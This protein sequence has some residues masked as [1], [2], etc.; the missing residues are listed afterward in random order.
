MNNILNRIAATIMPIVGMLIFLALLVL[1]IIFFSYLFIIIAVVGFVLFLV[2]YIRTRIMMHGRGHP[3][4]K[5]DDSK[6]RVIDH[7][8]K[9]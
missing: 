6:G 7:D 1:A 8:D 9:K 5:Q 3:D 2:G 4:K